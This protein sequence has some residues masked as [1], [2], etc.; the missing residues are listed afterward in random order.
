[1]SD[2]IQASSTIPL[3]TYQTLQGTRDPL[4]MTSPAAIEKDSD[5]DVEAR[6]ADEKADFKAY[7]DKT[8]ITL[9]EKTRAQQLDAADLIS[10]SSTY[11]QPGVNVPL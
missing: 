6:Q 5:A 1:M 7:L 9:L 2:P 3:P 8:S 11:L 10:Q 4:P